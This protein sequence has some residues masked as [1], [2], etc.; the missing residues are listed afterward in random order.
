M[1]V[2]IGSVLFNCNTDGMISYEFV[3]TAFV[4]S[5]QNYESS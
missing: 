2:L 1:Y 4:F 3:V 5:G